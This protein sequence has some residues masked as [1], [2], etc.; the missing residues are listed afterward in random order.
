MTEQ[1]G[2]CY[3]SNQACE[4]YPCHHV[5][6]PEFFNCMMCYCPLYFLPEDCGGNY[7]LS[8]RGI[9]DCSKCTI[10]HDP[11]GYE[12]IINKLKQIMKDIQTRPE[13]YFK[14]PEGERI[15]LTGNRKEEE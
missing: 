12:Y 13:P 2:F 1:N 15:H 11:G 5:D 9:R 4:F 10:P 8:S 7:T 6:D 3:F 14:S